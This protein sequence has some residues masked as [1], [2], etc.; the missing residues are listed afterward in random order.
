[1]TERVGS[2]TVSSSKPVAAQASERNSQQSA[3]RA[4]F[5]AAARVTR[6]H[7]VKLDTRLRSSQSADS[8]R[9]GGMSGAVP[10]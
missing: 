6:H 2:S 7:L 9:A 1:M 10:S 5:D 3:A 4:L 8:N